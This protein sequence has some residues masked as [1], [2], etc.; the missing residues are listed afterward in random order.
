M[1][2]CVKDFGGSG[3]TIVLLHGFL[4]SSSYWSKLVP[5]LLKDGYRVVTIDLLGFGK[6]TKPKNIKYDYQNHINHINSI[7]NKLGINDPFILV[8]HSMGGLIASRYS[9]TYPERIVSLVLLNSPICKNAVET[10]KALRGDGVIGRSVI[11]SRFRNLI[12]PIVRILSLNKFGLHTKK[13]R[14]GSLSL[15]IEK[16]KIIDELSKIEIPTLL[17]LGSK[18]RKI[19]IENIKSSKLSSAVTVSIKNVSHNPARK[20]IDLTH[21]LIDNFLKNK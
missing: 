10:K 2:K 13:S 11:Y 19:Y 16:T 8:G 15:I 5:L 1:M 3:K 7:I 9:I 12:W 17:L 14:D 18:D 21:K 20:N 6:A 4:L